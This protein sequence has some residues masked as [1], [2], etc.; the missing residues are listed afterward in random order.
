MLTPEQLEL[1]RSGIGS[2]DIAAVCGLD[3]HRQPI[4]VYLD[5]LGLAERQESTALW[6]GD[7]LEESIARLYEERTGTALVFPSVTARHQ[8]HPFVLATPDRYWEDGGGITEIKNVGGWMA[9]L[10]GDAPHGAP[11]DK[12]LQV[13]WQLEVCDVDQGHIAALIGGTDFRIYEV[14]R[15]RELA[16]DLLELARIFWEEHVLA[17]KPPPCD[18]AAQR[19]LAQRRWPLSMGDV[20][21][22]SE[23]AERLRDRILRVKR[24]EA[25]VA[26]LRARLEAQAMDMVGDAAG[27]TG[28]FTWT[29]PK[30]DGPWKAAARAAFKDGAVR[31]WEQLSAACGDDEERWRALAQTSGV[32]TPAEA[33][34]LG[35]KSAARRF[36]VKEPKNGGERR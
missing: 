4:D 23:E 36:L 33:M 12:V 6:L 5:K 24:M 1:R 32:W 7:R 26:D 15:D 35:A 19:R 3:P 21:P 17:R 16:A 18:G 2:S 14:E 9:P 20:L 31:M 27:I 8:E 30:A 25:R 34:T 22:A 28:C 29:A 13:Q 10:W 11:V